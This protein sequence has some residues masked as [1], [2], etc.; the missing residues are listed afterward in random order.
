[1][2]DEVFWGLIIRFTIQFQYVSPTTKIE[3]NEFKQKENIHEV[4]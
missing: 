1:M 4:L 2:V 3:L